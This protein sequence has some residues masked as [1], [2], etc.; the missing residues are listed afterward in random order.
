VVYENIADPTLWPGAFNSLALNGRLVT[1]G[2]HGGGTVPLKIRDLYNRRI[3]IMSGLGFSKRED[4]ANGLRLA[5]DGTFRTLINRVMPLD[6]IAE[7]HRIVEAGALL[8]KVV[9]DPTL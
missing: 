8:G 1:V 3:H 5:A 9:I 4:V 6:D 2:A 7:A